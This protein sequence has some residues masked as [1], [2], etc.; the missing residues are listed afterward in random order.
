MD[1]N[2][3]PVLIADAVASL[4]HRLNNHLNGIQLHATVLLRKGPESVHEGAAAIR[5]EAL[6]AAR[7]LRPLLALRQPPDFTGKP[8]DLAAILDRVCAEPA[9]LPVQ[10]AVERRP[11]LVAAPDDELQR[12]LG[13]VLWLC[14]RDAG[15]ETLQ[16][17]LEAKGKQAQLEV[18]PAEV[19]RW[20]D[21]SEGV[22][23]PGDELT[24]LAVRSLVH[25][26]AGQI[27]RME[28]GC[29]RLTIG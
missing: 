9:G 25:R 3:D 16:L 23:G 13:Y 27:D 22:A 4:V 26:L 14:Q 19:T 15:S 12:L 20:L 29:L 28:D 6:E 5:A 17:Q 1:D 11:V 18:R 24:R 8:T 10:L 7:L 21:E 2:F